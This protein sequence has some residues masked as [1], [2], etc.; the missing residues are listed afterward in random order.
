LYWENGI[1]IID[2]DGKEKMGPLDIDR[3]FLYDMSYIDS[4]KPTSGNRIDG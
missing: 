2:Y 4:K 1:K 3:D